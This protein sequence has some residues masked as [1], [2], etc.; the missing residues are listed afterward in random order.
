MRIRYKSLRPIVLMVAAAT[1]LLGA[2]TCLWAQSMGD[3]SGGNQQQGICYADYDCAPAGCLSR[4]HVCPGD[5]LCNAVR[6]VGTLKYGGCTSWEIPLCMTCDYYYCRNAD[7]YDYRILLFSGAW[8]CVNYRCW[9][10]DPV[11]GGCVPTPL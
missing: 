8:D 2:V 11:Q 6:Y 7:F 3:C 9:N 5:Q 4:T 10:L 1:L